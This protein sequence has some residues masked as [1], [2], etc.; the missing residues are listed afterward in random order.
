MPAKS[1]SSQRI[2]AARAAMFYT[3]EFCDEMPAVQVSNQF[4]A[5]NTDRNG[6]EWNYRQQ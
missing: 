1:K 4:D 2:R 3:I 5:I 6:I